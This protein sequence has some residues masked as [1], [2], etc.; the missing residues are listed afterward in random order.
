MRDTMTDTPGNGQP[1]QNEEL[2]EQ[3]DRVMVSMAPHARKLAQKLQEE[4]AGLP[5][6][7]IVGTLMMILCLSDLYNQS[8]GSYAEKLESS[9]SGLLTQPW[10]QQMVARQ[11]EAKL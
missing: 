8:H 10:V 7:D 1:L 3:V 4:Y 2:M 5:T 11:M 9:Y 6:P